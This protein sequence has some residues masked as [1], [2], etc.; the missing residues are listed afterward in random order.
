MELLT[1]EIIFLKIWALCA[2]KLSEIYCFAEDRNSTGS[3]VAEII[4][5]SPLDRQAERM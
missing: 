5:T 2:V 3:A 1:S 4:E